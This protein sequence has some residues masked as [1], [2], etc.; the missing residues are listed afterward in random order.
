MKILANKIFIKIKN[1]TKNKKKFI[2]Y[3]ENK[4]KLDQFNVGAN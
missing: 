2:I 3:F 4:K 1:S